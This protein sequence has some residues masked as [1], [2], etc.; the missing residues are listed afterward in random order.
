MKDFDLL[1]VAAT[2]AKRKGVALNDPAFIEEFLA[3][4]GPRLKDALD[5]NPLLHGQRAERLFEATVVSL[6]QYRLLKAEDNGRVHA[7]ETLRAPD[8]RIVLDD[9][10]QWLVEVKNVRREDPMAQRTRLSATYLASLRAYADMV[11][12]PLR[13]AIYWSLWSIWTLVDP[14]RFMD[15][16]GAA[17]IDMMDAVKV[18]EFGRLGDVSILTMHPLRL[19]LEAPVPTLTG[20]DDQSLVDLLFA[21][22]R[23]LSQEVELTD[24]KDRHMAILLMLY[25]EWTM[26]GGAPTRRGDGTAYIELLAEP[27]ESSEGGQDGIGWAS[28]IFSRFFAARTVEQG[29]IVQL[30]GEAVPEWFAPLKR[31]EFGPSQLPL[32]LLHQQVPGPAAERYSG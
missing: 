20:D 23:V 2:F 22:A 1:A 25:G 13:I 16:E 5:D 12:A 6:G 28:R 29:Q 4:A 27:E 19:I 7:T 15:A 10:D 24:P 21:T 11:G 30:N 8:F 31:W 3:D 32:V 14:A 18:N 9:G 17:N 26:D